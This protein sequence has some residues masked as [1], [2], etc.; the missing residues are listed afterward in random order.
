MRSYVRIYQVP[1]IH[2]GYT[3]R[4]DD[5][6]KRNHEVPTNETRVRLSK[7]LSFLFS[8][9]NVQQATYIHIPSGS[10]WYDAMLHQAANLNLL[11]FLYTV[12]DR[13][14]QQQQKQYQFHLIGASV[15]ARVL[16]RVAGWLLCLLVYPG[17]FIHCF[18]KSQKVVCLSL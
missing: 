7:I 10:T 4:R 18:R 14:Q 16:F 6:R 12:L 13:V 11:F 9:R 1:G 2:F 15:R 5:E 17:T 3:L 8:P